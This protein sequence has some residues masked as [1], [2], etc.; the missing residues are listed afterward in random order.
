MNVNIN[1]NILNTKIL[2]Y[3]CKNNQHYKHHQIDYFHESKF[4]YDF[5]YDNIN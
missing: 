2:V 3:V 5:L 1:I 4:M